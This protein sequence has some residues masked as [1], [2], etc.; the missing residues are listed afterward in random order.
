[1][2]ERPARDWSALSPAAAA[3]AARA[4]PVVILPLAATEQHGPHLPLSTDVDIGTGILAAAVALL[5]E[6][7]DV[8]TLPP[9]TVGASQEHTRF[10][11][12]LSVST[13]ELAQAIVAQ[14]AALARA[15]VRRLVLSNSH[16][17]NRHAI[18]GAALGLRADHDML[19]VKAS[20]FRFPHPSDVVLPQA[21]W[22]HGLH[23]GAIETAMMLHL[24]PDLVRRDAVA[25]FTSIGAELE[26]DMRHVG[27][28]GAA[29]FAWLAGDLNP[30]G[31]V[32]DATLATPEMGAKLVGHYARVLAEIIQDARD[33][34]LDR[35]TRREDGAGG[36]EVDELAAWDL[37]RGVTPGST[38]SGRSVRVTR[39][40]SPSA[41]VDVASD[42][43][44]TAS[45]PPT[46]AAR[47][48]LDLYLPLRIA[49]E[50]VI[51]Q[52]GQS[53]DG[54]IATDAGASHFVTGAKDI[55]RLHRI[56]ALVDA[57][58]VGVETVVQDDPRLTVRLVEGADPVR[59]VLDPSGRLDADRRVFAEGGAR[60]I[61]V[62]RRE[63][64][65]RPS[66]LDAEEIHVAWTDTAGF[67]LAELLAAL[68]ERGLRR[69]LVEGGGVTVSRFLQ[70]GLLDRL[71]LTV[72]PLL[73]GSGRPSITLESIPTLDHAL[74]PSC[75][76]FALGDDVLFDL[77]L[78]APR[79]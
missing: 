7:L 5:P 17:G 8:W 2:A 46:R 66:E 62:R 42:G 74:R 52:L 11:G 40:A 15:G 25:Q 35:L 43:S 68:G 56:R 45:S 13:E 41:W 71:H 31:V 47:D 6:T 69:I 27:P 14:G 70:A 12:T 76:R 4:D 26:R 39:G 44:W 50:I 51:G 29:P 67:D 24:R 20:W 10:P 48:L 65:R 73:I 22:R 78:R 60:T 57:V 49:R 30:L 21:E 75:R 38:E 36:A 55:E 64:V 54:R 53:L 59:V 63:S 1:V 19:V 33:F 23:G 37:V 16:G 34:P 32:G 61:V 72:A 77:D 3:E 79:A 28:E 58:I 9:V 18:D